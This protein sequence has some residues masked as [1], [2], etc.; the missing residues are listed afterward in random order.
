M[1]KTNCPST[2]RFDSPTIWFPRFFLTFFHQIFKKYCIP[3]I[4]GG[5]SEPS[6]ARFFGN[7]RRCFCWYNRKPLSCGPGAKS[8]NSWMHP[9]WS[10]EIIMFWC[11][12]SCFVVIFLGCFLFLGVGGRRGGYIVFLIFIC[13]LRGFL[14]FELPWMICPQN[15]HVTPW[16]RGQIP[17]VYRENFARIIQMKNEGIMFFESEDWVKI[18]SESLAKILVLCNSPNP[19]PE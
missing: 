2:I 9:W 6:T 10:C 1:C 14:S 15:S 11:H 3:K 8:I 19:E 4:G 12:V 18:Q 17:K 5:F 16:Y 7:P 13:F